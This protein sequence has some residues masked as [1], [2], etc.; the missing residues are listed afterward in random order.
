MNNIRHHKHQTIL[1]PLQVLL[2][3]GNLPKKEVLIGLNKDEGPYLLIYSVPGFNITGESLITRNEFLAGVA[4]IMA[5]E[6]DVAREAAISQ[7]TDWTDENNRKKNRDLLGSLVG[8]QLFVCPV[9]E[10]TNR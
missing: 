7:Y 3:T 4:L 8:N 9:L 1:F 2:S 5:N 6:S 10:F